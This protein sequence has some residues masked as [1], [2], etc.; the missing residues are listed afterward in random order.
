MPVITRSIAKELLVNAEDIE[1]AN[2]LLSLR[3]H[4][5]NSDDYVDDAE[6]E[7]YVD[8][9]DDEDYV[10]EEDADSDDDMAFEDDPNDED[11]VFHD[12]CYYQ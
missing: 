10:D 5:T 8:D 7:D 4:N 9:A 12:D 3:Y 1:M 11:Y 6:D 2:I